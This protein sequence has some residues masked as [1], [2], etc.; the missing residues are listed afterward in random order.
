VKS[1]N[2]TESLNP[3]MHGLGDR[4]RG[5]SPAEVYGIW[6]FASADGSRVH[7]LSHLKMYCHFADPK[8]ILSCSFNYSCFSLNIRA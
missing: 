8:E 7:K 1:V 3:T 4:R 5:L 6:I 2:L